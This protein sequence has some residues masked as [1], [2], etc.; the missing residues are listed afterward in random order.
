MDYHTWV[1]TQSGILNPV[2]NFPMLTE[3]LHL[4]CSNDQ[5]KF[6][7]ADLLLQYAYE[8]GVEQGRRQVHL[9]NL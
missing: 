3:A 2:T 5:K 9:E 4:V 6:D 1:M 8:A 7:L